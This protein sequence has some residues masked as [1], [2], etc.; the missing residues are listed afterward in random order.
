[1]A[2]A[3]SVLGI[4]DC[5]APGLVGVLFLLQSSRMPQQDIGFAPS[6][7][8]SPY[9]VTPGSALSTDRGP[10]ARRHTTVQILRIRFP[11]W[12]VLP[13][14]PILTPWRPA[15]ECLPDIHADVWR[16]MYLGST[17]VR[18]SGA[19][20]GMA[21]AQS[22]GRRTVPDTIPKD[23]GGLVGWPLPNVAA[24]IL[25]MVPADFVSPRHPR[26]L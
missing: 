16:R 19:T 9:G 1:M 7:R 22:S 20:S 12:G 3:V 21:A 5:N 13:L 18:L 10:T 6:A 2:T 23:M 25:P 14:V 24:G 17:C 4:R 26:L 8:H 11:V 15:I